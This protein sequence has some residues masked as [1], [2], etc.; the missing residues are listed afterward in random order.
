VQE[1]FAFDLNKSPESCRR[2]VFSKSPDVVDCLPNGNGVIAQS[3]G[4]G[5]CNKWQK[6]LDTCQD[7]CAAPDAADSCDLVAAVDANLIS[8]TM[9]CEQCVQRA[10]GGQAESA[11]CLWEATKDCCDKFELEWADAC[12]FSCEGNSLEKVRENMC[13]GGSAGSA[14]TEQA[15]SGAGALA[16]AAFA[17]WA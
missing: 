5:C 7:S 1:E 3:N 6:W 2:C 15:G 17:F 12:R 9:T 8:K 11:S 10:T 16:V 14:L 13:S 4:A